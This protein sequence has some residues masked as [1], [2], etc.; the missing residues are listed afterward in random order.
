MRYTH[1]LTLLAGVAACGR[2][3]TAAVDAGS[4]ASVQSDASPGRPCDALPLI[5]GPNAAASC[6]DSRTVVGGTFYRG[7]DGV[8]H[9]D[10]SHP[11]KVST[12]RLDTY[13]VTVGRFRQ[14]VAAGGGTQERPPAA[15]AG[16]RM[17]NG[18]SGQGGWDPAWNQHLMDDRETLLGVLPCGNFATW[19]DE[20]ADNEN[21]PIV[22][23]SWY[24]AM[25]FCIWDGGFLPTEA[26]SMYAMAGGPRQ[27]V[28]PWSSPPTSTVL[29]CSRANYGGAMWPTT[30]CSKT[31]ATRVGAGSPAG[32]GAYFQADLAGNVFEWGLDWAPTGF[33]DPCTDCANLTQGTLSDRLLRG[34]NFRSNPNELKGANSNNGLSPYFREDNMGMRCARY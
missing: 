20:P 29:D 15:G 8:G 21:L 7:Y 14:F 23:V 24:E 16:A 18:A 25:A 1:I 9:T 3:N 5:C 12:F 13:E 11:A 22:C 26:E 30:A 2:V 17:L 32:D 31:G 33:I 19:T 6:C 34:G 28:Y 10:M 4:D 27:R